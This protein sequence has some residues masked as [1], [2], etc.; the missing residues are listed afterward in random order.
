V[1]GM[2][3]PRVRLHAGHPRHDHHHR[4]GSIAVGIGTARE[5]RIRGVVLI[6]GIGGERFGIALALRWGLSL[7]WERN[8]AADRLAP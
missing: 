7:N 3:G 6:G 1:T 8:A 5:E 4:R 2:R